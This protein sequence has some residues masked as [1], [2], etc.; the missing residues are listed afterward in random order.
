MDEPDGERIMTQADEHGAIRVSYDLA[1]SRDKVWR[2][3]SDPVLL[4]RWLMPNDIAATVG[5]RFT[6]RTEP[7]PRFDG[8]VHCE[9]LEANAPA[10]LVY[11]W[12]GG[13]IETTVSWLL[14]ES[15]GG[16]T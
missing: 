14:A 13:T 1:A 3:L 16:G 7:A 8:I 4:G 9:I 2:A 12:K 11:S 15:A 10:R 5:H 6:F